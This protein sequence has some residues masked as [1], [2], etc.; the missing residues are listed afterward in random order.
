M[1]AKTQI[2]TK[3]ITTAI[4]LFTISCASQK[5]IVTV[6]DKEIYMQEMYT[7]LIAELSHE[8]EVAIVE[9]SIKV[10]FFNGISFNVNE[11]TIRK[12]FYPYFKRFAKVLNQYLNTTILI[13]GHAD[14]TGD[15]KTNIEISQK[16]ADNAKNILQN[17]DVK[18]ERIYTLGHGAT[19]PLS[20]N[21]TLAGR[22]KN[23]R[24]EFVILY[25]YDNN[26]K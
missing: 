2:L 14:S 4:I 9:D 21:N 18:E 16:R 11:T 3:I 8:A 17:F 19:L 10:I 20:N 23:R 5:K 6:G 25:N 26:K 22:A 13:T 24:I 1:K 15:K 12:E 7:S